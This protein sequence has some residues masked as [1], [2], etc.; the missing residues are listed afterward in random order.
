LSYTKDTIKNS[1]FT[2]NNELKQ[3][4]FIQFLST[5]IKIVVKCISLFGGLLIFLIFVVFNPLYQLFLKLDH[6]YN[7]NKE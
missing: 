1:I 2:K 5:N 7:W 6:I 4:E 3:V